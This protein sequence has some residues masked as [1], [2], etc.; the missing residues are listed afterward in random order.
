MY[1]ELKQNGYN[2]GLEDPLYPGTDLDMAIGAF[3]HPSPALS[4][5][6]TMPVA[7]GRKVPKSSANALIHRASPSRVWACDF[8]PLPI[9]DEL[10]PRKSWGAAS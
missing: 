5:L 8:R 6:Y 4:D 10:I 7:Q 3:P 1:L 2:H 9:L